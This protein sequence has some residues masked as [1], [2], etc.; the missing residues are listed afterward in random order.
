MKD[1]NPKE[2]KD[3]EKN[4]TVFKG[5]CKGCGFCIEKCPQKAISFSKKEVGVY[6]TPTVE[7]DLKKCNACGICESICPDCA[8]KVEKQKP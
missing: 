2:Q 1:F 8:L 3:K 7:I 5:L 4:I 6:S